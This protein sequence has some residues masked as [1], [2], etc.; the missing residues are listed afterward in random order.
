MAINFPSGPTSGQSFTASSTTWTWDGTSWNVQGTSGSIGNAGATGPTGASGAASTVTGPTGNVGSTGSTGATGAAGAGGAAPFV[1]ST[2]GSTRTLTGYVESG[3]TYTVRT[4]AF[5]SNSFTLTLATFT[6]ALSSTVQPSSTANWDVACT[7]FSVS[8]TNPSDFT[9]QYISSVANVTQTGGTVTTLDKF[10]AAAKSAT[11]AGGVNWTQAFTTNALGYIRSNSTTIAGGSAAATVNFNVTISGSESLYVT[12]SA[13]WTITWNTPTN[14]VS[15]TNLTGNT[16]LQTYTSTPYT[17]SVTGIT[18]AGN[19]SHAVTSSAGTLSSATGSGT[20]TFTTPVHK[21]NTATA[22][23]VSADTTFTRPVAVTGTSYSVTLTAASSSPT[24]SFTYPSFWIFTASTSTVPTK[25]TV[26]N[27][28]AFQSSV[29]ALGDQVKTLTGFINNS[30]SVPQAL[31]FGVR[32]SASQPTTFQTGASAG[33]LSG[34]TATTGNTVNLE[35]TTPP[36]G[37]TAVSYTLYGITLQPGST[38]V[39]IS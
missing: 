38:Y 30:G 12:S 15:V 24:A 20:L 14:S 17:V 29:T 25:A 34:V 8:V 11:P 18:T 39:S 19:Y 35:P 37:Y 16:F 5:V 2:S 36:A 13:T 28:S 27:N 4:A 23:T 31:W 9:T 22:R 32:T 6:P 33:L 26:I 3:I 7:G 10:T 1:F 21:D